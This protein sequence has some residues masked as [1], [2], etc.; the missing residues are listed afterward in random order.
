MIFQRLDTAYMHEPTAVKRPSIPAGNTPGKPQEKN[1]RGDGKARKPLFVD[2]SA[3]YSP[4]RR[5]SW[6]YFDTFV[7][8]RAYIYSVLH[9]LADCSSHATQQ[10]LASTVR[11]IA[12]EIPQV[13]FQ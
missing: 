10:G 3:V 4:V 7:F 12:S 8:A 5:V 6:S 11:E 13:V 9:I 2:S 1:R